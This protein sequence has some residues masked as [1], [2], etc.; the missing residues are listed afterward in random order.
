LDP[1]LT[2]AKAVMRRRLRARRLELAARRGEA[3]EAA[4]AVAPFALWGRY[5]VVAGYA[6]MEAEIDPGP[7]LRRMAAAGAR[8]VLPVV[9]ARDAPLIFRE[10]APPRDFLADAAGILA[11]PPTAAEAAPDLVIA[12]LLAFD[13]G[14]GRL[15]QGGGYYDRT[16]RA[17]R[18]RGPVW[19]VGLAY[20]G[21]EV[22][23]TPRGQDDEALDAILT[24]LAY[25]E[26]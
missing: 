7:L 22:A 13:R 17:L 8:I 10:V 11:P 26:V 3:S 24:E 23:Q 25:I 1:D 14:G 16:L 9:I 20:A 15:G 4:A 21:Q 12:P 18:A 2:R 6:P 5:R 19:V